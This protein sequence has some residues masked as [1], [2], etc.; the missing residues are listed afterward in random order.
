MLAVDQFEEAFTVCQDPAE[1][2]E[3]IARLVAAVQDPS[4]RHVVVLV[5]RADF[6]GQCA[7]YP[8]LAG[9]LAANNVLV[10]S[11]APDELRRAVEGPSRR[12][13]LRIE[14]ELVEALVG[15]VAGE[16][17]GLPLLSAA[18]LELWQR[19]DGRRLRHAT[20]AQGGGVRGAV[21]RLAEAAFA[22]LD[23]GQRAVARRV[24]M[25]LVGAGEGDSVERRRVALAE[26]EIEE[27]E[28]IA[29]VVALLTD[30]RLLTVDEGT[31]EVAHEALL[32]EW[33]RLRDWI[34]EDRDGLR[35]RRGL[36]L[37]TKEWVRLGRD[38]GALLRGSRL[39]EAVEWRDG[40]Q[41]A[42]SELERE[43]LDASDLARRRE[44]AMRRRRLA[45][46][47]AA[48]TTGLVAAIVAAVYANQQRTIAES[49]DLA[50]QS[51]AVIDTDP[52]LALV[53]AGQALGRHD[54]AQAE[55]A[56]RQATFA[57]RNTAVARASAAGAAWVAIPSR[58]GRGALTTGNDGTVR[59]WRLGP[60]VPVGRV[61]TKHG[62]PVYGAAF[63][64]DE[65]RVASVAMDGEIALTP[66]GGGPRRA[67]PR[68]PDQEYGV[69]VDAGPGRLVVGGSAGGVWLIPTAGGGRPALLGRHA[70][71]MPVSVVSFDRAGTMVVSG[72]ADGAHIWAAGH[73]P[74]ALKLGGAVQGASFSPNGRLVATAAAD[75]L[76]HLWDARTGAAVG[77]PP[78]KAG[79]PLSSV[80]FSGDGRRLA[81]TAYDGTVRIYDVATGALLSTMAGG[82]AVYADFVPGSNA[83]ISAGSDGTLRVW[84]PSAPVVA[85]GAFG[86]APS[87]GPG[88]RVV[89][90]DA[91]GAVRLWDPARGVRPLPGHSDWSTAAFSPDG[92]EIVSVSHD[93]S[94]RVYDLGLGRSSRL[95]FPEFIKN[96][97]A[98]SRTGRIAVAGESAKIVVEDADGAHRVVLPSDTDSV[99]AVA[100]SP[101]G[102]HLA[103]AGN[104]GTVTVWDLGSRRQRRFRADASQVLDLSYDADGTRLATAGADGTVRV[105]P[106]GGG[107]PVVLVGHTGQVNSARFDARGDRILSAGLDGTVRL[108]DPAG[109]DALVVLRRD[110]A[111]EDG[112]SIADLSPDG[113]RLVSVGVG[114]V[115]I[116]PCEPGV[117]GSLAAV[118][119]LAATR[120]PRPLTASERQRLANPGR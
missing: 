26:L 9:L 115:L 89:S 82:T 30:R 119:R 23:D 110:A 81:S 84:V 74:I 78:D 25:R 113:S 75:G 72:G 55:N 111:P 48:L 54:T 109:G 98:V 6:Y 47:F 53:L 41:I 39:T 10:R 100:F 17:G 56:L 7:A 24:L 19:R 18:L 44:R 108:W 73:R 51:S 40:G 2:G 83:I 62:T 105:Y 1:R 101:D 120:A 46:V 61:L 43:F 31:V 94:V 116:T 14:P 37:A 45:F 79:G 58:D 5:L 34:E 12:A 97:V 70:M 118:R 11:M 96:T 15:E 114:G 91:D 65:T 52:G 28:N 20:Y 3:F 13:G 8:E 21:A 35:V 80:R 64:R 86:T 103:S 87:F 50:T 102:T 60:G 59:L 66:V 92:R 67:L 68:L 16:P 32:R 29:R 63:T 49:R 104:G 90:G 99:N 42:L 27:D 107:D 71:G 85:L 33:P 117:C 93:S 88:G 112:G 4:G 76:V 22:Q 95:S 36:S 69:S 38:D 77:G 57:D 106:L